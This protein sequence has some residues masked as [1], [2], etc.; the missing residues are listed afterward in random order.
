MLTKDTIKKIAGL[1]RIKEDELTTAITATDEQE[2]EIAEL[3]VLDDAELTKVKNAEYNSGK[4]KGVEM[5]VKEVREAA[6]WDITVKTVQGIVDHAKKVG[7]E[8]AKV[9]PNAQVEKYKKDNDILKQTLAEKEQE[10]STVTS[11]ISQA[12]TNT[13]IYR[14]VPTLGENAPDVDTV[15][16]IMAAKGYEFK[17]EGNTLVPYLNGEPMKDKLANPLPIKDVI[18]GFAIESKLMQTAEAPAKGRGAGDGGATNV[19]TKLSELETA[20]KAEGKNPNGVE[21][22]NKVQELKKANP[23]FDLAA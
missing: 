16:T 1:L 10:L 20:W 17:K 8:E 4:V 5:A 23:D 6:G 22:N 11:K 14:A 12:E 7:F 18:T 13:E 19:F 3:T 21:F 15:L 9:E 2:L